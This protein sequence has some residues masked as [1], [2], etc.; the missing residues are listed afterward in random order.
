MQRMLTLAAM[1]LFFR[2][3]LPAAEPAGADKAAPVPSLEAVV[4]KDSVVKKDLAYG[5][6]EKQKLDVYAPKDAK[7]LPVVMYIHGGEWT[8]GDKAEVSY[9]PKFFTENGVVFVSVNYRLSPAAKH[10]DHVSD[11]AAAVRWVK[12]HIGEHGGDPKKIVLMGHSAG[13]HL[14]VLTTL[15]PRYLAAAK[16]TTS[17][18]RS[19][20]CWSGGSFDLP[21]KAKVDEAFAPYIRGAFGADE[22]VWKDASPVNLTKNAKNCPPYLF[23]TADPM[24]DSFKI[25]QGLAKGIRDAGGR[26]STLILKD[27]THKTANAL[28]G[29]PGDTTGVAL[30]EFVREV[31]K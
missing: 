28:L 18:V 29:S 15:D 7:A 21:H 31:T 20:V 27:R 30:L 11:V 9:K 24:G 2:G 25:A 13:C 10:P 4:G 8:K 17:D 5:K 1:V 23:V 16:L 22:A 3:L 14:V 12:E 19:V 26:S 6:E